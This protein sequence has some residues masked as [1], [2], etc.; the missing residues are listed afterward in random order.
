MLKKSNNN[1]ASIGRVP[2]YG[3]HWK[4]RENE[5]KSEGR[6]RNY[7]NERKSEKR[8]ETLCR[9]WNRFSHFIDVYSS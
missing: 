6:R 5:D 9:V 4:K 7:K 2:V 1:V 3:K 8:K